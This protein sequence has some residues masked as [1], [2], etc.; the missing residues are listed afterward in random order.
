M[1]DLAPL[2]QEASQA[3]T[4]GG[5]FAAWVKGF[6]SRI[7]NECNNQDF[8][9][10]RE[11]AVQAALQADDF[12]MTVEHGADEAARMR[13]GAARRDAQAIDSSQRVAPSVNTPLVSQDPF[14]GDGRRVTPHAGP[15]DLQRAPTP[16]RE[17]TV[18][19]RPTTGERG[20]SAPAGDGPKA[21]ASGT[22]ADAKEAKGEPALSHTTPKK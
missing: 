6:A 21:G 17:G 14:D 8:A 4:S 2:H 15:T 19:A 18:P 5:R 20:Q 16:E 13:D 1:V 7:Q 12:A 10:I 9:A 11:L 3:T 22:P